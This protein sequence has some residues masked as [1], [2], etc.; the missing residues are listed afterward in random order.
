MISNL[1]QDQIGR[2]IHYFKKFWKILNFPGFSNQGIE[3]TA[4]G[5]E[6]TT[7]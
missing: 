7:T 6:P 1:D 2:L 5:F 4:T 3:V